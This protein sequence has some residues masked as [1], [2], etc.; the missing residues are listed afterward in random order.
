M[1]ILRESVNVSG[2]IHWEAKVGNAGHLDTA[3]QLR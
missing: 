3:S 1:A 2:A